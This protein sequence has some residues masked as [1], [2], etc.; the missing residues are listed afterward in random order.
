MWIFIEIELDS[1][2]NLKKIN[3]LVIL[4][5]KIRNGFAFDQIYFCVFLVFS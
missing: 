5:T 2:I 1:Y 3:M 4:N